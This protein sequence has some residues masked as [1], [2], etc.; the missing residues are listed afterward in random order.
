MVMGRTYTSGSTIALSAKPC[1]TRSDSSSI[2]PKTNRR[3]SFD[4][5]LII[6]ADFLDDSDK[7]LAYGM[8]DEFGEPYKPV[9]PKCLALCCH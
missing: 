9:K 7:G 3:I 2:S 8:M 5:A 4:D 1:D 6:Q